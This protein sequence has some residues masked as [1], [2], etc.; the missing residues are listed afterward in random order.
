MLT[1]ILFTLFQTLLK[2]AVDPKRF[3][4]AYF[5]ACAENGGEPPENP[6]AF[7]PWN[8]TDEQKIAWRVSDKPP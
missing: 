3:L 2:H 1:A 7:L 5:E 6:E 8:L 4:L